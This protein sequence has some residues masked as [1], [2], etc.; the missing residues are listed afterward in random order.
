MSD[1]TYYECV[2]RIAL[3]SDAIKGAMETGDLDKLLVVLEERSELMRLTDSLTDTQRNLSGPERAQAQALLSR[4]LK[5]TEEALTQ[6]RTSLVS[7]RV[8][9]E[10]S[11]K[12]RN[13]ASLYRRIGAA[14]PEDLHARFV[15]KQ[16]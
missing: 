8:E 16:S 7:T 15:D 4:M 2:G 1:L 3:Q 12:A 9:M 10:A 11:V 14:Q 6:V 13:S 5:E